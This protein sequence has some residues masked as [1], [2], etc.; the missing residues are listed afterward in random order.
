M[1]KTSLITVIAAVASLASAAPSFAA[2]AGETTT[3]KVSTAG[4][5][6]Q[7]VSGSQIMVARIHAAAS[8]V[9]GGAP[10]IADLSGS[11]AWNAC[12]T[13]TVRQAANQMHQRSVD[14]AN[15]QG[16]SQTLA[17]NGH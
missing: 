6:L 10:I 9:C 2:T 13:D 5:D 4:I 12:V 8:Q 14:L 17:S 15:S 3:F 7:T 11:L 16:K 1:L